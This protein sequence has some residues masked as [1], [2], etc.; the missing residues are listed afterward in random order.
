MASNLPPAH[1]QCSVNNVTLPIEKINRKII[2]SVSPIMVEIQVTFRTRK[3]GLYEC[4]VTDSP[5][6]GEND[7]EIIQLKNLTGKYQNMYCLFKVL[8]LV[9]SCP[10][11]LTAH[12]TSPS[13]ITLTWSAPL[14]DE[15]VKGYEVFYIQQD[16]KKESIMLNGYTNTHTSL[17]GLVEDTEYT[18]Y[19]VAFGGDLPSIPSNS[20][21]ITTS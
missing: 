6:D 18:V 12:K 1:V 11:N 15:H 21:S 3:E 2:R 4:T 10:F 20:V 16:G 7:S 8:L 14:G 13:N 17:T 19:V 9:T 5:V